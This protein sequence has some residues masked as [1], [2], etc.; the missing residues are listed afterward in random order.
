M[1]IYKSSRPLFLLIFLFYFVSAVQIY[2]QNASEALSL[3]DK[4]LQAQKAGNKTEALH[5]LRLCSY[6][7]ENKV[8]AEKLLKGMLASEAVELDSRLAENPD[9]QNVDK[10]YELRK[11]ICSFSIADQNDWLKYLQVSSRFEDNSRFIVAGQQFL[12]EIR[13]GLKF[14]RKKEWL[15]LFERLTELLNKD[16]QIVYKLQAYKILAG[17]KNTGAKYEKLVENTSILAQTRARAVIGLAEVS[18]SVGD[19]QAARKHLDQVK[20]FNPDFP[21]LQK[22]Y[23][24]LEKA[25]K[26][27]KWLRLAQIAMQN[28]NFKRAKDICNQIIEADSNNIFARELLNQIESQKKREPGKVLSTEAKMKLKL[29][30]LKQKLKLAEKNQDLLKMAEILKEILSLNRSRQNI[31]KLEEIK[32]RIMDSRI[33]A[34]ERFKQ[35]QELF[36]RQKYEQLRLFLN[37]NPGMMDSI[38]RLILIWEMKLMVDYYNSFKNDSE[39]RKSAKILLNKAGESFYAHYVLMKIALAENQLDEARLHYAEAYKLNPDFPGLKWPGWILWMHGEGRIV[40]VIVL[41]ILIILLVKLLKP[42]FAW[43]ES[44]YWTRIKFV[45]LVFPSLAVRSLEKCFG[46]VTDTDARKRL[47]ILL[48]KACRKSGKKEK[49]LKY[50]ENLLEINPENELALETIGEHIVRQ[51]EIAREKLRLLVKYALNKKDDERIVK[52]TGDFIKRT[53][54]IE[55]WQLDFLK[56]YARHFPEDRHMFEIAGK[57]L[58]EIPA[59]EMPDSAIQM[60]QIAWENTR[61]DELWWNLWR[62]LMAKGKFE[63]AT[64][65]TEQALHDKKPIS[66]EKLLEVFDNEQ[67]AVIR[68]IQ[69]RLDSF[70]QKIAIVAARELLKICYIESNIAASLLDTLD[71]LTHEDNED[72]VLAARQARDHIKTR[73]K[74]SGRAC[75]KLL[76]I[77]SDTVLQEEVVDQDNI[78]PEKVVES[79]E[80]NEDKV[81]QKQEA[82]EE[83]DTENSE[84]E[85]NLTKPQENSKINHRRKEMFNIL[86]ELEPAVEPCAEWLEYLKKKPATE[87]FTCLDE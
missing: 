20:Y 6:G 32:S 72:V 61:S 17:F 59:N 75:Q 36:A 4:A 46:N 21:G 60:L 82:N 81:R 57:S 33:H 30:K 76:S 52:K 1:K 22:A 11:E 85:N 31:L 83:L 38:D 51:P 42:F 49:S 64:R 48:I 23:V 87:L 73:A 10:L 56:A 37:K 58:L 40:V 66:S 3:L 19:L 79:A 28:R 45:S 7:K 41:I 86:D 80:Q 71:R 69:A 39:L 5:F 74:I 12:D 65:L 35:A 50:S 68:E 55:V 25:A 15:P 24:K 18:I 2:G 26:L 16:Y 8:K 34:E 13:L 27:Q 47:F 84:K 70:D 77:S 9:Q 78:E 63:L 53:Q 14:V 54:K 62:V 29:H 44:T 43:Y 67:L